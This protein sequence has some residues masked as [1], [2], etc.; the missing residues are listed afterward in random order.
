MCGVVFRCKQLFPCSFLLENVLVC[1][2]PTVLSNIMLRNRCRK[3]A[4]TIPTTGSVFC[5]GRKEQFGCPNRFACSVKPQKRHATEWSGICS[6][7]TR[8][9]VNCR[10]SSF[11]G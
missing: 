3:V 1:H 11:S 8:I 5:D 4:S 10:G 9:F 2:W 6:V 7:V